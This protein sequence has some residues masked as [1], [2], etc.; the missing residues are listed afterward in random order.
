M[1]Q[2]E[3]DAGKGPSEIRVDM[4]TAVIEQVGATWLT[5][6]YDRLC[7][8]PEILNRFRKADVTDAIQSALGQ[9]Q[10]WEEDFFADNEE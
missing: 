10:P 6:L 5:S 1:V 9:V 3:L 7:S 4:S 2:K 8:S